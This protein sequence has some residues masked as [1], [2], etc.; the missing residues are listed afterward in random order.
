MGKCSDMKAK[1]P[2]YGARAAAGGILEYDCEREWREAE[3]DAETLDAMLG[4]GAPTEEVGRVLAS[5][6]GRL[7][8]TLARMLRLGELVSPS[9]LLGLSWGTREALYACRRRLMPCYR[10]TLG[11]SD[12]S[13]GALGHTFEAL[14]R[15]LLHGTPRE[16]EIAI[17]TLHNGDFPLAQFLDEDT[18]AACL[19]VVPGLFSASFGFPR[20]IFAL[21]MLG[22]KLPVSAKARLFMT[23]RPF[24]EEVR[25]VPMASRKRRAGRCRIRLLGRE[26]QIADCVTGLSLP[27]G[28]T[29]FYHNRADYSMAVCGQLQKAYADSDFVRQAY[30]VSKFPG[31][32]LVAASFQDLHPE[33]GYRFSTVKT[34]R[35]ADMANES[36]PAYFRLMLD[37]AGLAVDSDRAVLELIR[38]RKTKSLAYIVRNHLAS[39]NGCMTPEQLAFHASTLTD[40]EAAGELAEAVEAA[41]PGTLAR[42]VDPFGN[43]PLWYT[44][45]NKGYTNDEPGRKGYVER[46]CR[47]GCDPRR[48]NHLGLCFGDL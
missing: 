35:I 48:R 20:R 41:A 28:G 42:A 3:A 37:I 30:V 45:Y 24:G 21:L 13:L 9:R 23:M 17:G 1:P 40:W 38:C 26:A 46:L 19:D 16:R 36:N 33:G 29:G 47:L 15:M 2:G 6:A 18:A 4:E 25:C 11:L 8:A 43:T 32:E 31:H 10:L 39:M 5:A 7:P 14:R 27:F 22:G 12:G 44:L 34:A